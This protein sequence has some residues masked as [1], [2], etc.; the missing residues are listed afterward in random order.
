ML[1]LKTIPFPLCLSVSL[2]QEPYTT[3]FLN[4]QGGKF[5]YP[6]RLFT[7][8]ALSWRNCQRDTSDVKVWNDTSSKSFL[9]VNL[10]TPVCCIAGAD[11]R[12]V[13]PAGVAGQC[14]SI[15]NGA[16]GRERDCF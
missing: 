14:Q 16:D 9:I 10:F 13:L 12:A 7:S 4:L 8:M 1:N 11:S 2:L 15:P 3:L 5:D 6:N